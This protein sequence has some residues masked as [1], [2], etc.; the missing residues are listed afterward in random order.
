[1]KR[2]K[3]KQHYIEYLGRKYAGRNKLKKGEILS[4]LCGEFNWSRKHAQ[5]VLRGIVKEGRPRHARSGGRPNSYS[6][7]DFVRGLRIVWRCTR[8]MCSRH[9]KSAM[10]RWLPYIEAEHGMFEPEVRRQL[11]KVSAS[12]MDRVLK[13]YKGVKGI[14]GTC[15]TGFRDEIPIQ[16]NIW[17]VGIPGYIEVDTVAHCG[18]SLSGDFIWSVVATDIATGWTD[19]RGVYGKGSRYVFEQILDIEK[20]LPF[21]LYGY[22]SDNG[23]EVLNWHILRYFREE[24]ILQGRTPVQVTRAREYKKNDNAH[25]EQ[26][27]DSFARRHLGY[28]RLG[29]FEL[30]PL[31]NYYYAEIVCP[32]MN[33]FYPT[34]KLK[35]KLLVQSKKRRI[36]DA[37]VTPYQRVMLSVHVQRDMK[38]RLWRI[39]KSLDPVRLVQAEKDMRKRIDA[40]VRSLNSGNS[41]P[42]LLYAPNRVPPFYDAPWHLATPL[43]ELI[44]FSQQARS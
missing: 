37:P 23:G 17:N 33:H 11:L 7:A 39:H 10:K 16:T 15:S 31:I 40:A 35:D 27:N 41:K 26:K 24:R 2:G 18:G 21:K 25:V 29:Y 13:P 9:L 4:E 32:L 14:S 43:N 44:S 28:E 3:E 22:D 12:T 5:R 36:Y 20:S 8:Y 42:E 30:M 34:F 6:N 1:M 38:K 19:A